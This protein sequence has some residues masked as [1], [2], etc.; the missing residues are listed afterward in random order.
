M[1]HGKRDDRAFAE[2]L[3]VRPH[4]KSTEGAL[5]PAGRLIRVEAVYMSLVPMH[6]MPSLCV[7]LLSEQHV[8]TDQVT[9]T[10]AVHMHRVP[11]C[12]RTL[13]L[14]MS[15]AVDGSAVVCSTSWASS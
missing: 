14:W 7:W 10:V 3:R 9:G 8:V 5:L 11:S 12:S 6:W 1:H 13:S 4:K 2:M 15:M